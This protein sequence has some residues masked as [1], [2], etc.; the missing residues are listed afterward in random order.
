D[1][2]AKGKKCHGVTGIIDEGKELLSEDA[3]PPVMDA[4][5]IAAA[6]KVEHY[7]MAGYGCVRTW[8]RTLGPD[9]A[10][11][12][13]AQTLQEEEEADR[14]LTDIAEHLINAEAATGA[15]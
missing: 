13:L 10:A 6:Q 11:E 2:K 8:A 9:E 7:E 15:R 12:L 1:V 5:I 14:K 4:G 3:E